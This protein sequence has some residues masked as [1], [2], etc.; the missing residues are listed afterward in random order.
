MSNK[1][2]FI[3]E[4]EKTEPQIL[5]KMKEFYFPEKSYSIIYASYNGEIYQL[6]KKLEE[7]EFL[8]VI[9]IIRERSKE[10]KEK[11][12]D[13]SRDDIAQVFLFFDYG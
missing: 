5:N 4:G 8:D 13:L 7:D 9:E 11:L 10:N 1:I 6:Y 3:F 12:A 2:L